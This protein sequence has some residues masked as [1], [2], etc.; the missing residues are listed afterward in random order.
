VRTIEESKKQIKQQF[1]NEELTSAKAPCS[2]DGSNTG[3]IC[4]REFTRNRINYTRTKRNFTKF[5][6]MQR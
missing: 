4:T 2:N 3:R 1:Q 6:M 5:L